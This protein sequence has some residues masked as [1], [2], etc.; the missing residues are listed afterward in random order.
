MYSVTLVFTKDDD[1]TYYTFTNAYT[2]MCVCV[3][4]KVDSDNDFFNKY[5][6]G[7]LTR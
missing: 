2:Y 3:C 5:V 7:Y 1:G 4:D 6:R